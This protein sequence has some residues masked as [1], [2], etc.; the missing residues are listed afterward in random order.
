MRGLPG[1]LLFGGPPNKRY[2]LG[3]GLLL[4]GG[5]LLQ[6]GL[7]VG[8]PPPW[9]RPPP[10]RRPPLWSPLFG[11]HLPR[12]A[13]YEE[14]S[15]L[16]AAPSFKEASSLEAPSQKMPPRRRPP[17][18]ITCKIMDAS[19]QHDNV[20]SMSNQCRTNREL[21]SNQ[22]SICVAMAVSNQCRI[23]VETMSN[24]CRSKAEVASAGSNIQT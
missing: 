3:G 1:S 13:S 12:D 6:G 23:N 22:S 9:R 17:P 14:A 8:R 2:L 4:G 7:L 11:S 19:S 21:T 5:P 15:S 10:S 16:E 18:R 24:Q 20:E